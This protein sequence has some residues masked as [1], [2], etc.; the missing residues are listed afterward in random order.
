MPLDY[1]YLFLRLCPTGSGKIPHPNP[2]N[3]LFSA[4]K[5][6]RNFE[7][8]ALVLEDSRLPEDRS[9]TKQFSTAFSHPFF[10][11]AGQCYT[12]VRVL[13]VF[14]FPLD[15]VTHGPPQGL[16]IGL[17]GGDRFGKHFLNRFCVLLEVGIVDDLQ[18]F[19]RIDGRDDR[20]FIFVFIDDHVT[21]QQKA[22]FHFSL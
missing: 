19:D 14:L 18:H 5:V 1:I 20:L 13:L 16:S 21:G 3:I 6:K 22:H 10:I 9:G 4:C 17:K 2:E 8:V 11:L 7:A 12:G 15:G